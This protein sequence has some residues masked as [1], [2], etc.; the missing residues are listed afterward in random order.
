[1][2]SRYKNKNSIVLDN[3][4]I[5]AEFLPDP[6]GKLVSLINLNS[7]FEFLVQRP[8]D[9]YRDQPFDGSYVEGECS[10]FDDMFPTIDECMCNQ[11]PW[12][13]VKMA[14]HGEVWSL[15]WEYRLEGGIL[16]MMVKGVRFPYRLEKSITLT[17]NRT[18]RIDYRLVNESD[19]DFDFLW[20]G[21]FMINME[22]GCRI[23]VPEDCKEAISILTNGPRKFGDSIDWPMFAGND[24]A[25]Y[26][27][28][29]SRSP[30]TRGFE[31]YYF[32]NKLK[33]GWCRFEYPGGE[34]IEVQFPSGE[35]PYLGI[36][37]NE[38]GWDG[39]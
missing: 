14:D 12:N 3:G 9:I 19:N 5:R 28:D 32:Q 6:G 25:Y 29:I 13:G 39:L 15:P 18:I 8:N 35:V 26:R 2:N 27:G 17:A 4:S 23:V 31:K 16:Y 7:G 38:N 24:G 33:N 36:L 34:H 21:H 1:M 20:A 10:G 30:A 37:M 22:E 11:L